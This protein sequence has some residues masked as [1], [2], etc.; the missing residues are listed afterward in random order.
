MGILRSVHGKDGR[1]RT[2]FPPAKCLDEPKK[3]LYHKVLH[4]KSSV[5]KKDIAAVIRHFQGA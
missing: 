5:P 1:K 2:F 3:A 4:G